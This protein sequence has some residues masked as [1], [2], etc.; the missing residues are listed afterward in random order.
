M[1]NA[2]KIPFDKKSKT[3]E[4]LIQELK[5]KGMIIKDE[6]FAKEILSKVSYYRLSG[7]WFKYQNKWINRNAVYS[8]QQEKEEKENKFAKEIIFE[9]IANIYKFDSKLRSLCFDALEKIEISISSVIC[10][11]MCQKYG[12]YWFLDKNN[13]KTYIKKGNVIFSHSKLLDKFEEYIN[14]SSNK[15][16]S[17]LKNFY[18]KYSDKFPPYWIISQFITFGTLSLIYKSLDVQD[19]MNIAKKLNFYKDFLENTLHTLAYIRNIC[20]HYSRLWDKEY[21]LTPGDINFKINNRNNIYN[22]SFNSFSNNASFFHVF[23]TI[24][25]FLKILYPE[26]KWVTL[27]TKKIEEYQPKTNGFVSFE[28]M[29]FPEGWEELPLIKEMLKNVYKV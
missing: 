17:L 7:Y 14:N 3:S 4:E 26:S 11:Y 15:K 20:A 16:T 1:N 6:D 23:Y 13:I 29:G 5:D 22:Y 18:A 12:A 8:S 25:L 21:S 27:V 19:K 24:A 2:V 9:N 10:D 28:R